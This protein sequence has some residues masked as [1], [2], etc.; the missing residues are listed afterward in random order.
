LVHSYNTVPL[1]KWAKKV[2]V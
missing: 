1:C 2:Q